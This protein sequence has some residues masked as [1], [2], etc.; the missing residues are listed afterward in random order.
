MITITVPTGHVG[1]HLL[2]RLASS[3]RALTIVARRP[4]RLPRL[5]HEQQIVRRACSEEAAAMV[6][7]TEG[8]DVLFWIS[9]SNLT[10]STVR[11]WYRRLAEAAA[12]GY[13]L[14]CSMR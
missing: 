5:L 11:G 2:E 7:A 3:G 1:R 12:R 13:A 4:E 14:R 6:R 9:P 8:T 10:A